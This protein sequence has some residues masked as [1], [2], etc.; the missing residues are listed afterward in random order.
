MITVRITDNATPALNRILAGL[1]PLRVNRV[2]AFGARVLVRQHLAE[3]NRKPNK[4]GWKKQNFYARA[5][6]RTTSR[7]DA[8][9]G[10][11]EIALEGFAQRRFGGPIVP[12]NRKSLTIPAIGEAYGRRAGEWGE[13][14][15][16]R[17]IKKGRLLGILYA[18]GKGRG[19]PDVT[20]YWL[21]RRVFQQPDPA[22]LPTDDQIR[23]AAV[24]ALTEYADPLLR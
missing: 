18:P 10:V 6:Q 8:Q 19:Q 22:V 16:F 4:R 5:R 20:V 15:K 3:L 23:G 7:A 11:V 2:A 14:L 1:T 24:K 21:L 13:R 17:P 9:K 12:V